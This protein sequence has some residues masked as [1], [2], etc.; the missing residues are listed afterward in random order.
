[1][2]ELDRHALEDGN[3]AD[4][5]DGGAGEGMELPDREESKGLEGPKLEK[6]AMAGRSEATAAPK[7]GDTARVWGEPA[8]AAVPRR[9]GGGSAGARV[10]ICF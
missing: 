4:D 6:S 8:A 10:R 7:R 9:G 5:G 2:G 1:V 3:V